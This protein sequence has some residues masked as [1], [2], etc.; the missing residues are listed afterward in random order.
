MTIMPSPKSYIYVDAVSLLN[1]F[2][3]QLLQLLQNVGEGLTKK[4]F[5]SE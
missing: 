3:H 4:C 2:S 1:P 5:S